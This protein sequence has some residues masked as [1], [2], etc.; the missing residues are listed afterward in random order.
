VRF[1]LGDGLLQHCG[2][3]L[4]TPQRR[5][6]FAQRLREALKREAG[7]LGLTSE[8]GHKE[9]E[10]SCSSSSRSS[11]GA[12]DETASRSNKYYTFFVDLLLSIFI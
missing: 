3:E 11:S 12:E 2:H 1:F 4:D 8:P 9:I 7:A 6:S 10:D 5:C